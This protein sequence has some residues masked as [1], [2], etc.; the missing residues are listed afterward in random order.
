MINKLVKITMLIA[1]IALCSCGN[2]EKKS[3]VKNSR[4][5]CTGSG[6]EQFIR[7]KMSQM[8]R[9]ILEFNKTGVRAYY[10]RYISWE[11]GNAVNGDIVLDYKNTPCRD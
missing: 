11:T 2:K 8:N 6:D 1:I 5:E 7:K 3:N 4:V 9:G 10:V